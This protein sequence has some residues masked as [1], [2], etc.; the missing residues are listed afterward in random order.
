MRAL[1][2]ALQQLFVDLNQRV[3]DAEFDRDFPTNGSFRRKIIKGR[4]YRY[5]DGY[6]ALSGAKVTKYAGADGNEEIRRRIESFR[7]I[8]SAHQD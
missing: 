7:Q 3:H 2:F 1:D 4:Y 6:D 8:K 5:Y